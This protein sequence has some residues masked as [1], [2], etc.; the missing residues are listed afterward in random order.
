MQ[1]DC[2]CFNAQSPAELLACSGGVAQ[3]KKCAGY[4]GCSVN[5]VKFPST[6]QNP[7]LIPASPSSSSAP[8]LPVFCGHF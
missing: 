4:F 3:A 6:M 1:F 7:V 8:S 2:F 5:N